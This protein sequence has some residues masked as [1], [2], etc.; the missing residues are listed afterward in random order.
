MTHYYL[1]D[2]Y[3]VI[4]S[5]ALPLAGTFLGLLIGIMLMLF[6]RRLS[7]LFTRNLEGNPDEAETRDK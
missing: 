6:S 4:R 1:H 5:F 2:T 7:R 3:Y